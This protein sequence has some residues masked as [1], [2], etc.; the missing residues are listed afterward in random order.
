MK[1]YDKANWHIDAGEN[2]QEVIEKFKVIFSVLKA[3]NMLS[4][5]GK[6]IIELGIDSSISLHE[7]LLTSEGNTFIE[8][9][10]DSVI[11]LKSNEIAIKLLSL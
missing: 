6:E 1:I 3:K 9:H 11:N 8:D 2:Q 10:Y 7:R 4:E 5:E